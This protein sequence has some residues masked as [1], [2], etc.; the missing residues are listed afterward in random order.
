MNKYAIILAAG[1]GTR[2]KS[3]KY[4]V[5]HEVM[6]KPMVDHVVTQVE[7]LSPQKIVT[8]VGH[9]ADQVKELL[10]D[11]TEYVMQEEQLGTGHAVLQ[12]DPVLEGQKG[13][14]LVVC[15]DTPL[16]TA[17]TLEKLYQTHISKKAKATVLTA[18][19]DN[20]FGYGRIIRDN[21]QN[22]EKIVEQKD[23]SQEE[24]KVNEVNTGTY[25]F[26]NEL[27]FELLPKVSNDN[28]QN[29]YYLPDIIELMQQ[30]SQIIA[31]YQM[32]NEDESLGVNDRIALSK[33]SKIMQQRINLEHMKN[34]VTMVDPD[35]TYIESDVCI[36]QDTVIEG[37]VLLK[38]KTTIGSEC[39]IGANSEIIDSLLES[40]V[41]I[42]N[43]RLEEA[44]VLNSADIGPYARLR[45]G[46]VIGEHVHIGDF[47]EVKN[48]TIGKDTKAGHFAYIGDATLGENINVGCGAIF[49]NYDGEKKHYT[50]VGN[51]VFIGSNSNL[52][53]PVNI[54]DDAFIAAGSTITDDIPKDSLAIARAR[55][56]N[57]IDYIK[58]KK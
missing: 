44:K 37:Q 30:R 55:Q 49:V 41:T 33:A 32:E 40:N 34:G 5:L 12:A 13:V 24:Q 45:P 25:C 46:S 3:K 9:G 14:T 21:N 56:V 58:N 52:V 17:D 47:V 31:A 22:V 20:P 28:A 50:T 15:G 6:G 18:K 27:L 8:I 2:M 51:N 23:A 19:V 26:D 7:K 39:F 42:I 54:D 1:K 16:L 10:G 29:E 11:R 4:K 57:K 43:S 38:G 36:G 53:A 48:A 35:S